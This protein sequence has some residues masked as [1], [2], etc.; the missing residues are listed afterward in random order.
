MYV[1]RI[2]EF[3]TDESKW[4]LDFHIWFN[5]TGDDIDP[6]ESFHIIEGEILSRRLQSRYD[7]GDSHY[8]LYHEIG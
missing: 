5:W 7:D 3:S 4:G 1:D 8:A 6:G 2:F